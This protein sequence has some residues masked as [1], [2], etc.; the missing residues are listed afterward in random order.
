MEAN[1]ATPNPIFRFKDGAS[2]NTPRISKA[3]WDEHKELLCSLYQEK[4]ISEVLAFM[5]TEHAFVAK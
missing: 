5:Q 4:T 1:L 2:R 3:K